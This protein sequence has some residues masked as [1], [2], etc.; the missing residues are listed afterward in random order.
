MRL[1]DAEALENIIYKFYCKRCRE[2]GC[3]RC[4]GCKVTNILGF[5]KKL[6]GTV[7]A[8]PVV[9]AHW[10]EVSGGRI[11]CDHCGNFPL[12][13]Y[14]GR[15]KLSDVCPSCGAQMDEPFPQAHE[16][17][18]NTQKVSVEKEDSNG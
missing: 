17:G 1:I 8:K 4:R 14:F 12:Y 18:N 10:N 2:T 9:H 6:C 11:I 16:N 7:E 3:D 5:M 15:L 13:D